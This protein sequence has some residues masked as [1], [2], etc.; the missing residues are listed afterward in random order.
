MTNVESLVVDG[1]FIGVTTN[2]GNVAAGATLN[3]DLSQ[4][5][6]AVFNGSAET[7]G[8]FHFLSPA[9][10]VV[11]SGGGGA[12]VFDLTAALGGGSVVA[13]GN[14]GND[15]FVFA[16]NFGDTA[17]VNGG[18]GSDTIELNGDYSQGDM[19]ASYAM[20]GIETLKLD[21]GNSYN[22]TTN[23]ANVAAGQTLTV[24]ASALTGSNALTFNGAAESNG[25]FHI[26]GGAGDDSIYLGTHFNN[27]D[28][29]DGGGGNDTLELKGDYSHLTAIDAGVLSNLETLKVDDGFT[30]KFFDEGSAGTGQTMTVDGSAL[31]GSHTL[32][33]DG[34]S[35]NGQ[36]NL[37]G[38]AGNDTLAGSIAGGT[39]IGGMGADTISGN[40][41]SLD[42]FIYNSAAE[43]SGAGHYD[44]IADTGNGI[45]D[46]A[47]A[48]SITSEFTTSG[49]INA[50][51]FDTDLAAIA[52]GPLAPGEALV[53]VVISGDLTGNTFLVIDAN[54]DFAYT[55][56]SDYVFDITGYNAAID[57]SDFI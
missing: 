40:G 42:T 31:T 14:G 19:F 45:F 47:G 41:G 50:A 43:S 51:T 10:N 36:F 5:N 20:T 3:V 6:F 32:T 46:L 9:Q 57:P 16:D 33:F 12:D 11:M 15:L 37:I 23:N 1:N 18:A 13:N 22:L 30:Y 21:D 17:A 25:Y 27:N 4:T 54:G 2:D 44:T 34:S 55:P 35:D 7:D 38:G 29:I 26:L 53:V 52:N 24:D 28:S 56:G 39:F 48:H 49:Q 8:N